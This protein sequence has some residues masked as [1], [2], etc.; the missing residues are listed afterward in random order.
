MNVHFFPTGGTWANCVDLP[1][2]SD[3]VDINLLVR[4]AGGR[5]K[6]RQS[7]STPVVAVRDNG[8]LSFNRCKSYIDETAHQFYRAINVST[9]PNSKVHYSA[10]QYS[11]TVT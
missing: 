5:R 4:R 8:N 6:V 11:A 10:V 9:V 3:T 7:G 2:S 1:S